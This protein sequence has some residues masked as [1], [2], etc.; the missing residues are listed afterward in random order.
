MKQDQVDETA[1]VVRDQMGCVVIL[2]IAAIFAL[3][4]YTTAKVHDI[5]ERLTKLELK[6]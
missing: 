5:E 2:L 4:V 1:A 3:F 6:S